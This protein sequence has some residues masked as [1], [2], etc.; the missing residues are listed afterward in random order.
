MVAVDPD[1]QCHGI[2]LDLTNFALDQIRAA[3]KKVAVLGTGGDPG[4]APAR[5]TYKKAGFTGLP[6][7]RFYKTL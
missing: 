3:G 1:Y 2:G 6:I 5:A 4:H 7:E